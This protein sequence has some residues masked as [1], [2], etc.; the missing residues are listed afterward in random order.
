MFACP[1]CA[2]HIT[3]REIMFVHLHAMESLVFSFLTDAFLHSCPGWLCTRPCQDDGES[4][5][6]AGKCLD[7][8]FAATFFSLVTRSLQVG[9]RRFSPTPN[10]RE[11]C[12]P[13][14]FQGFAGTVRFSQHGQVGFL[15]RLREAAAAARKCC[16][17]MVFTSLTGEP[18][19]SSRGPSWD[20]PSP[21]NAGL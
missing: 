3:C 12:F 13:N 8:F 20:R 14:G 9:I 15:T 18:R 19:T 16:F 11:R 2:S 6:V 7:V 10:C 21:A 5:L 4:N 17:P 1:Y